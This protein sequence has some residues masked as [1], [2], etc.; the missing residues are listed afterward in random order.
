MSKAGRRMIKDEI[1]ERNGHL[2]MKLSPF[3]VFPKRLIP[4][5]IYISLATAMLRGNAYLQD[6][7]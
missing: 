7:P 6:D 5:S 3:F 1:K 2:P 4:A